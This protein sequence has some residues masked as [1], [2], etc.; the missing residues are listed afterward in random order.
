MRCRRKHPPRR[1]RGGKARR[2]R[3]RHRGGPGPGLLRSGGTGLLLRRGLLLRGGLLRILLLRLLRVLLLRRLLLVLRVEGLL[4]LRLVLVAAHREHQ[5]R[6]RRNSEDG[7]GDRSHA[8]HSTKK[9]RESEEKAGSR[10]AFPPCGG[11]CQN[12]RRQGQRPLMRT[13]EIHPGDVIA[14]KYRVRAILGRSHGLLVEGFHTEFDQRVVIKILLAGH[15]EE[16]EI[17][18]FRREART[19][20]KLESE[21]VARIIDVGTEPDGSFYLIRQHLDGVDLGSFIRQNGPLALA[22]AVLTILQ[23]A[24][25]V[26]ETHGHGII[27]RELQPGHLFL[28]QRAGGAP[29]MKITDF[30]TAK[31]LRDA[32]APGP[33]GELT[34]TAMFGLSPY[35]SPELLRKA[36]NVD[37]RT[38]VW[39]L[40]AILY[41]LVTGR[42]PFAGETALLMLQI[43][44]EQPTPASHLVPGLPPEVDQ[45][46]DWALAKDVDARFKNVHAFAHALLPYATAEGQVLIERI[47]QIAEAS[48]TKRRGGS[49][50]PPSFPTSRPASSTHVP[51]MPPPPPSS[52]VS[53][54]R[55]DESV[56]SL[57]TPEMMA[58]VIPPA[59]PVPRMP[60][61]GAQPEAIPGPASPTTSRPRSMP[62]PAIPASTA[63]H[64]FPRKLAMGAIA[65]AAV[66][67]PM[68]VLYV[69]LRKGTTTSSHELTL[70]GPMPTASA[71]ASAAPIASAEPTASAAPPASAPVTATPTATASAAIVAA[72]TIDPP[73]TT[74]R[75]TSKT[76]RTPPP[77]PPPPSG[78][79]NGTLLA[80]A[81]G[82][83]CAFSV[84]GAGKGTSSSL[85][86]SLKPGTYAVTCRPASG[87]T[88]SKSV[89]VKSGEKA[90]AAFK[91]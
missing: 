62:P 56:T 48:R 45:I 49:T 53:A 9:R 36:K 89:T 86:L 46:L 61:F 13:D 41:E 32:A 35:S 11:T 60:G 58:G 78:G 84:N 7:Q 67:L 52:P 28:T 54:T 68:L 3:A 33:S 37:V 21:H 22:D 30:G 74:A 75:A 66:V 14:G 31:L 16:R 25:A 82:G 29:L 20:A 64:S 4:R 38:D 8:P 90:M 39:S 17:E 6:E 83:T 73:T 80:V 72:A 26:A 70:Q 69:V 91:L 50:P 79:A 34:A 57:L 24:E 1:Q 10:G 5:G 15:G 59:A 85:S 12:A 43:T 40:G 19:L 18:R 51:T 44:R 47:G 87:A 88:K 27:V 2:Q 81:V 23:V 42:P 77:P 71:S 63:P 76:G 55:S 65:V